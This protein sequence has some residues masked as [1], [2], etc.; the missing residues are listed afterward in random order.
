MFAECGSPAFDEF[1]ER[2]GDKVHKGTAGQREGV[3]I[4]PRPSPH[5]WGLLTWHILTD[6][7][8]SSKGN[9]VVGK[10]ESVLFAVCLCLGIL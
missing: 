10:L 2:M 6:G 8:V 9:T 7:L 5:F 1:L 3:Q 4:V